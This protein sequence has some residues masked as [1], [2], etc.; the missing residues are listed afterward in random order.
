MTITSFAY[1]EL[2][3]SVS[4]ILKKYHVQPADPSML[5]LDCEAILPSRREWVSAVPTRPLHVY[6]SERSIDS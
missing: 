3:L 4:Q 6:F 5:N 2:Y 1:L